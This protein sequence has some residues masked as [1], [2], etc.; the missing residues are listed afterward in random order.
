MLCCAAQVLIF[1]TAEQLDPKGDAVKAIVDSFKAHKGELVFVTVNKDTPEGPN[2]LKFFDAPEGDD[3][4]VSGLLASSLD[5]EPHALTFLDDAHEAWLA[6]S[7][8]E[9]SIS[10]ALHSV[11]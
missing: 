9:R 7:R 6:V 10:R 2:V 3:V 5:I 11:A 1:G 4:L 8:A